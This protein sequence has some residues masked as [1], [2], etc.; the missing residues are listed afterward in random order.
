MAEDE[1][2]M[3]RVR[4]KQSV[5]GRF[6]TNSTEYHGVMRFMKFLADQ[7][8]WVTRIGSILVYSGAPYLATLYLGSRYLD[9]K[10]T[11]VVEGIPENAFE[12]VESRSSIR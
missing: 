11:D 6:V 10:S 9:C 8:L 5:V 4:F 2:L 1:D 7:E 12:I 3:M